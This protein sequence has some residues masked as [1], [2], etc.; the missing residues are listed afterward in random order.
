M[1]GSPEFDAKAALTAVEDLIKDSEYQYQ[2]SIVS[3]HLLLRQIEVALE[4]REIT[5]MILE[6]IKRAGTNLKHSLRNAIDELSAA[7]NELNDLQTAVLALEPA[8]Q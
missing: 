7:E 4:H 8:Q 2:R 1:F 5:N 3:L 6:D